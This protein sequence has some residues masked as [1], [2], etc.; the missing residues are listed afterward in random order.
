MARKTVA[1]Q[2]AE[3]RA[4]RKKPPK[5]KPP[6][7]SVNHEDRGG[8]RVN[9][10][11]VGNARRLV[12]RHGAELHFVHPWN[13]WLV[14]DGKRW[15]IDQTGEVV[16]RV[17]ETQAAHFHSAMEQRRALREDESD[18]GRVERKRV[19]SLL[20]HLLKW[21]D[22]RA[23]RRCLELARSE[24]GVPLLPDDLDREPFLLNVLNGTL[25]LRTGQLHAHR[26]DDRL[27]KM[28]A[29]EFHEDAACPLWLGCVRRWM[30]G[31]ENLVRYLQRVVGHGLT[32]DVRE[33]VVWFFHGPGANGK[34]TFLTTILSMLG[35]Y[36]MQAIPELLMVKRHESHPTERADLF[37]KRLVATI[38]TEEGKRLAEALMKQFTGGERLRGR[39]M[40]Q[41][42]FEFDPTAK[43]I[44]AAN[45]KPVIR[46]TDLAVWRRIKMVPWTVIIPDAAKDKALPA[47][48]RAELPGILAWAVIGCLDW[49]RDGLAEPDE[50]RAATAAYRSEQD[51]VQQFLDECCRL[52][53]DARAQS[54]RLLEGYHAWSGDKLMTAQAFRNSLKDKGFQ[55]VKG[56]GGCWFWHGIDLPP[57]GPQ[58]VTEWR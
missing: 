11:D 28:A 39:K 9:L 15:A 23:I 58:V 21:E 16:R 1:E 18:Q 56:T 6:E 40:R 34:S 49:Q 25:D 29:V 57:E 36:G 37:G 3:E 50:V 14:W 53:R 33:Q 24:P 51:L 7:P 27:T 17:K 42:F 30:N 10:T 35:D 54:S 46:G 4:A 22:A 8:P 41:D 13:S 47:K 31:N 55:S 44:L 38:E 26:R 2:I 12:K 52:H 43:I 45:H 19:D 5:K 32:G 48:L 20:A